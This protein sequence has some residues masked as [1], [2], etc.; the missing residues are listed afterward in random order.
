MKIVTKQITN[1]PTTAVQIPAHRVIVVDCSGSM[2][3]E[4][5]KL[6]KHLKNKLTTMVQPN[7]LL[8]IIWFSS[9][10]KFGTLF[11]GVEIATVADLSSVHSAIDRFLVPVGLTG[12]EDPLKDVIRIAKD[13]PDMPMSMSFMT[14]G[15]ENQ[16]SKSAIMKVC[17][18][19][20]DFV[21]SATFVEYGYYA[22]SK[23]IVE[24]AETVGAEVIQAESFQGYTDS[25]DKALQGRSSGKRVVVE[26][27]TADFVV[28]SQQDGFVVMKPDASGKVAFPSNVVA[29]SFIEGSGDDVEIASNIDAAYMVSALIQRGDMQTALS[30]AASIGD[31][32]I[33]KS[34]EN[35][36]SKQDYAVAVE[37]ANSYGSGKIGLYS[38]A[39]KQTNL[40]PDPNAY[41]VL[42]LLMDLSSMPGNYL[43]VSHPEFQYSAIGSKREPV[44]D[45]NGFVPK[46]TDKNGDILAEITTLKFDEDRP[47]ISMLVRRE[48]TVSLPDNEHGFGNSIESFIWRNYAIV[49]DGIVNVRKLPLRLSKATHDLLTQNG[50]ITEPFKVNQTYIIDTKAL[51]VIN[52]SMVESVWTAKHMFERQFD[53]YN[54]QVRFKILGT[55]FEKAEFAPAFAAKY[56]D[57]ATAFL[58]EYG[59]TPGG[60]SAKTVKGESVDPY[61]AKTLEIKM[62]GLNTIPKID[63]VKKAIADG[64]KL[65]PSQQVV[66]NQLQYIGT[67]SDPEQAYLETRKNVRLI[68]DEIVMAKFGI[69]LGKKWFPD[70]ASYEED[71]IEMDFKLGK[72]IKCQ[73]VLAD[74]EI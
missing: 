33:Y 10:G 74:K 14:D 18:E 67:I 60:F 44:A 56:G 52:R 48:G 5:P 34:V 26:N 45:A 37:K 22:D 23:M 31:A 25:L 9:K 6:R 54:E 49:R 4:L 27:I 47:N 3:G 66:A 36:F 13:Y 8:T 7:D 21:D 15:G 39:P 73:A 55:M 63:D 68:R 57:E 1:K 17:E 35:A 16:S 70:F 24:M 59:V 51:P 50:V 29:Y 32:D 41:N 72:L 43:E 40:M 62:S 2:G 58:K 53:M 30:V 42:T 20:S 19:L 28:G 11:E 64:K 71:T 46:F 61:V 38:T 65:T 12:F 69:I